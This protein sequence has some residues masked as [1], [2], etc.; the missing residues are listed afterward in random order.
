MLAV[1]A[2]RINSNSIGM[3]Y[4][5][6]FT[7]GDWEMIHNSPGNT[8]GDGFGFWVTATAMIFFVLLEGLGS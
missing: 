5:F 4:L 1:G 6:R 7:D 8:A 2:T 3:A